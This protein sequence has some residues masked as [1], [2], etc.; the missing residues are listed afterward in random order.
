MT[1][2]NLAYFVFLKADQR[3]YDILSLQHLLKVWT[4]LTCRHAAINLEAL[5]LSH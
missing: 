5:V 4:L 3:H 2:K 1:V